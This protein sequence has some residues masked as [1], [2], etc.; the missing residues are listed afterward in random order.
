[1]EEEKIQKQK[2]HISFN[3]RLS[4]VKKQRGT[5]QQPRKIIKKIFYRGTWQREEYGKGYYGILIKI[6]MFENQVNCDLSIF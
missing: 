1:M 2:P 3:W 5:W 4:V 6:W